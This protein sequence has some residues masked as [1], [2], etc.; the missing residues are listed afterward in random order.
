M[1]CVVATSLRSCAAGEL[2]QDRN[3]GRVEDRNKEDQNGYRQNWNK[4]A[5]AAARNIYQSRGR[6]EKSDKHRS[7]VAH[8]D[9][10]RIR[11]V[12]QK[13]QQRRRK[14]ADHHGFGQ[15]A[16]GHEI[17]RKKSRG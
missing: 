4:T 10:R 6:E 12:N 17:Q 3:E 7:A 5:R 15:L 1:G 8:K 2:S 9:R 13:S 11:V 16:R 14:H